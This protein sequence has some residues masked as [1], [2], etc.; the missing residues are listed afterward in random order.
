VH[1]TPHC[2]NVI[3]NFLSIEVK[4][5]TWGEE[6]ERGNIIK[7]F[8]LVDLEIYYYYIESGVAILMY[9]EEICAGLYYYY[10]ALSSAFFFSFAVGS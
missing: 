3:F 4:E 8:K 1:G 10:Y 2:T 5:G 7:I 6:G 9:T